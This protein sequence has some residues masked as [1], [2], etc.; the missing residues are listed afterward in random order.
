MD[1]IQ[2][3]RSDSSWTYFPI[4]TEEDAWKYPVKADEHQPWQQTSCPESESF[5]ISPQTNECTGKH[6]TGI[7]M[8]VEV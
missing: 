7:E 2:H 8:N 5:L 3:G 4:F 6:E 1:H